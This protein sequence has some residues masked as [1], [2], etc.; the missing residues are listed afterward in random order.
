M[1]PIAIQPHSSPLDGHVQRK[2]SRGA[3][4]R[5]AVMALEH[6]QL[7]AIICTTDGVSIEQAELQVTAFEKL[8]TDDPL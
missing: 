6:R 8:F 2:W 4:E 5:H 3:D 1:Y 7:V